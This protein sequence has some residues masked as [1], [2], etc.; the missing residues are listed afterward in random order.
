MRSSKCYLDSTAPGSQLLHG[1]HSHLF[2]MA[3]AMPWPA[4]DA[5]EFLGS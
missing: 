2:K 3:R 4:I 5:T 1:R